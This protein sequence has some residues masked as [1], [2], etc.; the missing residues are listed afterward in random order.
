MRRESRAGRWK[1]DVSWIGSALVASL[2]MA[3]PLAAQQ[4]GAEA[5]Q[6][7][8]EGQRTPVEM[9][10]ERMVDLSLSNSYRIR[11]LNLGIDRTRHR[12]GAEEARLKTN[13]SLQLSVPE[14]ESSADPRWNSTLGRNE[15]IHE[16]TRRWE[17][18]LSIRQPVILFGYP[19]NGYLSLNNRVYRY[20]Q[21]GDDGQND[22]RYYNRYFVRYTQPLFQPNGLKNDLEEAQLNL[23]NSELEFYDDV[24][25]IIDDVSGDYFELFED[26]Y[27]RVINERL[28]A[29]LQLAVTAA[30][31]IAQLDPDRALDL[32]Q[33]T[34]ELANAEQELERALSD[35]R[36]RA[37]R[38]KTR[39]NIPESD[40]ITLN[41]MI[42]VNPVPIDIA[43]AT[44]FALTATP[45]MRQLDIQYRR[46]ELNLDQTKGRNAFRVN[47]NFSYGREAL[48]SQFRN[49]FGNPTN[50]YSVDVTA[51]IPI[52]DG[53]E[54]R[55][56]IASSA[57]RIQQTGLRIEEA[58]TQIVS[59]IQNEVR[60]VAEFQDRALNMETNLLLA[61]QLSASTLALY[62]QGSASMFDLLQTFRTEAQTA[63]NLLDAYLGWRNSLLRIQEMTY[64]DFEVGVPVLE[65][66]GVRLPGQ[67]T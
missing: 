66:Y 28:V 3:G 30:E 63:E 64:F 42:M 4:G 56:R 67:G 22:L 26:A 24:V 48:D 10:L 58:E 35:F 20:N 53:G 47:L 23:E 46:N 31:D 65:R 55:E 6:N 13:V 8:G 41:P 39:L 38:L 45:R 5:D 18:T 9:T 49:V 19:T 52:W 32:N 12:L 51:R 17:S 27:D 29:N 14:F 54:R 61:N 59:R 37:A 57:I 25:E 15:I 44:E 50:T 60:N 7:A 33:V 16:T 34:V 36:I 43:Q 62:V 11:N 2:L 40:S 21:I 1:V